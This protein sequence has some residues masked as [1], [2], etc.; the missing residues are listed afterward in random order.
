MKTVNRLAFAS[1]L[2]LL[3][4]GASQLALA[5]DGAEIEGPE[6][7][8]AEAAPNPTPRLPRDLIEA[9]SAYETFVEH[10]GAINARFADG[11]AIRTAMTTAE[12]WQPDQMGRGEVA[13]AA[14]IALQDPRFVQGVLRAGRSPANAETLVRALEADPRQVAAVEGADEAALHINTTLGE[15]AERVAETGRRVKQSAYD[16]QHQAWSRQT[17]PDGR[18]RLARAKELATISFSP[19]PDDVSHLFQIA[20]APHDYAGA[21]TATP[22]GYTAVV[23]RGLTLAAL[24]VLG[25]ADRQELENVGLVKVRASADCM[26][27]AK[28]N[29]YQCLAVAGPHYEDIF[30]L[31]EHALKE[32]GQ[33][34]RE[35]AGAQTATLASPIPARSGG[36][37][38][39]VPVAYASADP[40]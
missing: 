38:Y 39:T 5:R 24:A 14:L 25:R 30:C 27:M 15:Q 21:P 7:A 34:L 3:V 9:A 2:A 23:Q 22:P 33:C 11:E 26:T 16:I 32:T 6:R 28:L 13:Y 40:R 8:A 18:A 35:G 20:A 12:S 29:L 17:V 37:S 36:D 31:G 1:T 10:A 19:S 4:A